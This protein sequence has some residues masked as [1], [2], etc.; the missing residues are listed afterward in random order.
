VFC[1]CVLRFCCYVGC[2]A[3]TVLPVG[4]R[5]FAWR[6]DKDW[7]DAHAIASDDVFVDLRWAK[8][9]MRARHHLQRLRKEG[10]IPGLSAAVFVDGR[11]VWS[12]AVLVRRCRQ[13]SVRAAHHEI[14]HSI[15]FKDP[16]RDGA[17][18]ATRPGTHPAR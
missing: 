13:A 9:A 7:I 5:V 11:L 6:L 4:W 15:A 8:P 12:E 3:V 1:A 16:H 18:A 17:L 14:P 10:S 2:G